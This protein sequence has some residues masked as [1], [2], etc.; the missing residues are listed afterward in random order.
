[1]LALREQNFSA[2]AP[3][4]LDAAGA[5]S[6][7]PA[8]TRPTVIR[9]IFVPARPVRLP[10]QRRLDEAQALA[11]ARADV[12]RA[13]D[14]VRDAEAALERQLADLRRLIDSRSQA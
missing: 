6:A 9:E 7:S 3:C 8:L 11:Q 13:L 12:E 2:F 10:T 14:G 1:M 5:R 4:T